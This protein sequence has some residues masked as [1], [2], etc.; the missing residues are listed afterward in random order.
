[1]L[2]ALDDDRPRG[3]VA[4]RD[5]TLDAQEPRPVRVAQQFE[6]EIESGRRQRRLVAHAEGANAGVVPVDV[7]FF[8][9]ALAAVFVRV[10]DVGGMLIRSARRKSFRVQ[11]AP[12][13]GNF[14]IRIVDPGIEK[15]S[16]RSFAFRGVKQNRARIEFFQ[17]RA[18]I[19]QGT[20]PRRQKIG[21]AEDEPVGHGRLL[22]RLLMRV[23]G[24]VS[25]Y[26][27]DHGD[28]AVELGTAA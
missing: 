24:R 10:V 2:D 3:I 20:A 21:L 25:I 16:G 5:N 14:S 18:K 23:E 6:E 1:M 8:G 4:E 27:I 19:P 9:F 17:A 11:P 7:V 12:N 15:R 26:R 28:D 13:V 22:H